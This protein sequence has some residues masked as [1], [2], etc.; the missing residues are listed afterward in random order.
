MESNDPNAKLPKKVHVLYT[1]KTSLP[2]QMH[3]K[4]QQNHCNTQINNEKFHII[5]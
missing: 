5:N 4:S 3:P 1:N 2:F